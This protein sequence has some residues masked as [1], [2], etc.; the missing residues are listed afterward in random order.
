MPRT[1]WVQVKFTSIEEVQELAVKYRD[2]IDGDPMLVEALWFK[3]RY[4]GHIVVITH[5]PE[6]PAK[7]NTI[8]WWNWIR[9]RARWFKIFLHEYSHALRDSPDHPPVADRIVSL[10]HDDETA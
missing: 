3:T 2:R 10:D 8:K 4:G 1:L 6:E 7:I 5:P 9:Q